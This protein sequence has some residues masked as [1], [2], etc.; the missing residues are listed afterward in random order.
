MRAEVWT[1]PKRTVTVFQ[2][3]NEY[4]DYAKESF[5]E[6]TYK[7]KRRAF[8][9]LFRSMGRAVHGEV[10]NVSTA[11]AL[12]ALRARANASTGNAANADRREL[13]AAWNW[14]AEVLD[15]PE[16]NPFQAVRPFAEK[17]HPRYVPPE[18]DFWKVYEAANERYQL[19]LLAFLHTAARKSEV[20]RLMW[21]DVDF[22]RRLIRL[23]TRKRVHGDEGQDFIPMT[24]QLYEALKAHRAKANSFYVFPKWNGQQFQAPIFVMRELCAK[25]A[26][27]P[28]GFHAIRHLSASILDKAGLGLSTIQAILRHQSATTTARY[29]HSLRGTKVALDEVFGAKVLPIKKAPAA[30]TVGA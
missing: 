27:K 15:L 26:V 3:S 7:A 21:S 6:K 20:F 16:K 14:G 13:C 10:S 8:A 17:R 18:S 22:E 19:V 4:L 24:A 11:V 12:S 5:A 25:A 2:W 9:G 28:F 29:L 23:T 30:A 1:D